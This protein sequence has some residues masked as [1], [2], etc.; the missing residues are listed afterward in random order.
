[1]VSSMLLFLVFM[2][3]LI[4]QPAFEQALLLDWITVLNW[5]ARLSDPAAP[6][7]HRPSESLNFFRDLGLPE[8]AQ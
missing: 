1:M 7:S 6:A 4:L 3:L 2:L 5:N 8:M